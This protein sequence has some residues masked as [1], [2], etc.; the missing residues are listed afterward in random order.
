VSFVNELTGEFE[1][2]VAPVALPPSETDKATTTSETE[3]AVA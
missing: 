1:A 3:L 2:A